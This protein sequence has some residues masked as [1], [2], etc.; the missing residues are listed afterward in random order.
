MKPVTVSPPAVDDIDFRKL[1]G[2]LIDS[3]W[4]IGAVTVSFTAI[5]LFIALSSKPIYQADT[6][7]KIE[8]KQGGVSALFG[9]NLGYVFS[10]N[11]SSN[12][13]LDIIKSRMILGKTVDEL[14]LT[15]SVNP[16]YFPLLG[17]RWNVLMGN[18]QNV[19]LTQ[20]MLP[21]S[22]RTANLILSITERDTDGS[23]RGKYQ[24]QDQNGSILL[25]GE[26]GK[27]ASGNGYRVFVT[28]IN[29]TVGSEFYLTKQSR[30]SAIRSLQR[31][32]QITGEEGQTVIL[33]LILTGEDPE[34]LEQ[35]LN[36]IS[37]NYLLQNVERKSQEAQ[38]SLSFLNDELPKI[39]QQLTFAENALN[40][41]R[42]DNNSIDLNLEAKA[43]LT[44]M[45]ETEK[46]L[47]EFVF[48]E[49]EISK[50]FKKDHPLYIALLDKQKLLQEEKQ[51]IEKTLKQLPDTQQEM[52]R[53]IRDV[54]VNQQIYLQ[55]I[56]IIQE[57]GFVKAG[58]VGYVRII[59]KAQ[60]DASLI[61]PKK[62]LIIA[63]S[64]VI[65][66]LFI[67]TI[68][69]GH[70]L[71]N[72][73]LQDPA[74]IEALGLPVYAS[75]PLSEWQIDLEKKIKNKFKL[76]PEESLLAVSNPSDL[77]IESLRALRTSLHLA[78]N[79][80]KN[81]ILMIAGPSP[82]VGKSFISTN[83]AIIVAAAGQRV[84]LIDADMRKGKPYKLLLSES[85]VGLSEYLSGQEIKED[86]IN[87]T[88]LNDGNLDVISSGKTPPNP[89]ELLMHARFTTLLEWAS[90]NYDIVIIDSP[91]I[92]AVTDAAIIGAQSG[93][94][95]LVARFEKTTAKEL[96]ITKELFLQN[97][98]EVKGGILNCVEKRASSRYGQH[99]Y[100]EYR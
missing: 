54:E 73:R 86:I 14:D 15:T 43:R 75:L 12:S 30:L 70:A 85:S 1:F 5:G 46:R 87:T 90:V 47:N 17:E 58:T 63:S 53:L 65:G 50:R 77:A 48:E 24:I 38:R 11:I 45:V 25:N 36:N 37:K 93:A 98:I 19:S 27:L 7:L 23:T 97:N 42:L 10:Q 2:S 79:E 41:Y 81:N 74:E 21:K 39:K 84:L 91:S 3:K 78:L 49:A 61:A 35:V 92:L 34:K 71:F 6:L 59:D 67:V 16:V 56:N 40:T 18:N 100:Y 76:T 55:I 20:F 4:I 64:S 44:A 51:R 28:D 83:L 94:T 33:R 99:G 72:R 26:T 88:N 9:N 68:V 32:L 52:L 66:F 62:G 13:E 82:E 60:T 80:S 8:T 95:L 22:M 96:E 31:R 57:F 89:S 69:L 29:A